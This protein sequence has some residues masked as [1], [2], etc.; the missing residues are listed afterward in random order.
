MVEQAIATYGQ[1]PTS[2]ELVNLCCRRMIDTYSSGGSLPTYTDVCAALRTAL[3]DLGLKLP[4]DDFDR[5]ARWLTHPFNDALYRQQALGWASDAAR[6]QGLSL[7]LYGKGWEN[8]PRFA[9]FARGPVAYGEPLAQLTRRS[10]INLQVVPYLCLHQ[11]LLDGLLAG[12]FFLVR[13]HPADV[14]PGALLDFLDAHVGAAVRTTAAV[15]AALPPAS[16]ARFDELVAACRPCLCTTGREDV[17]A[18]VRDW[19][20]AGQLVPGDGPLPLLDDTAFHDAGSLFEKIAR[21]APAPALREATAATQRDS[22]AARLTYDAG[23]RRVV[24]QIRQ[25]LAETGAAETGASHRVTQWRR[26]AA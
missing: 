20:E 6:Q 1:T 13:T 9:P 18:M 23:I 12:G 24:G 8:H 26:I 25:L 17:V 5:L 10:R 2:R 22:V 11:R 21:F 14:A 16:L 7:A 19:Q 3:T 15:A 4:P